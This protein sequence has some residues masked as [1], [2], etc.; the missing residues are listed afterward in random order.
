MYRCVKLTKAAEMKTREK[1]IKLLAVDVM[2]L[3]KARLHSILRV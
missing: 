3:S 1:A 2:H